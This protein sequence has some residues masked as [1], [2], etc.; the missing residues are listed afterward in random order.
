[1]TLS[2]SPAATAAVPEPSP[3][4]LARAATTRRAAAEAEHVQVAGVVP[5][6]Q[7]LA[8]HHLAGR[9]AQRCGVE[10]AEFE[11]VATHALQDLG[12]TWPAADPKSQ[13]PRQEGLE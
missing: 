11:D 1:M 6:F 10:L 7:H 2:D 12:S 5:G 4:L 13:L 9:A 3:E 8:R